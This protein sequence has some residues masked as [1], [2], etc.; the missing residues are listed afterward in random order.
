MSARSPLMATYTTIVRNSMFSLLS[1]GFNAL[2]PSFEAL[3]NSIYT[4]ALLSSPGPAKLNVFQAAGYASIIVLAEQL[5]LLYALPS[6]R[7]LTNSVQFTLTCIKAVELMVRL[8]ANDPSSDGSHPFWAGEIGL[9][10]PVLSHLLAPCAH[11][12][13]PIPGLVATISSLCEVYLRYKVLASGRSIDPACRGTIE[14]LASSVVSLQAS[15]VISL[16]TV[17]ELATALHV[18]EAVVEVLLGASDAA[19]EALSIFYFFVTRAPSAR[20]T[21]RLAQSGCLAPLLRHLGSSGDPRMQ[22]VLCALTNRPITQV[23][24]I[25]DARDV[26]T[27]ASRTSVSDFMHGGPG[28]R[29]QDLTRLMVDV[30]LYNDALRR[31][32][33]DQALLRQRVH[34]REDKGTVDRLKACLTFLKAFNRGQCGVSPTCA[35]PFLS[36]IADD[37]LIVRRLARSYKLGKLLTTRLGNKRARAVVVRGALQA[38]LQWKA[39]PSVAVRWLRDLGSL[40]DDVVEELRKAQGKLPQ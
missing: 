11:A 35:P 36:I 39:L 19:P 26:C 38:D 6:N 4:R 32:D 3:I 27:F 25:I 15:A 14:A 8:E 33:R 5:H 40:A 1:N 31:Y 28:T 29:A 34:H 24:N 22:A 9:V 20:I 30:A 2:T 23:V 10:L 17:H 18:L 13:V 16:A 12:N 37:A 21:H 7:P